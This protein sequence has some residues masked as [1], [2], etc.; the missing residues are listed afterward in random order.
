MDSIVQNLKHGASEAVKHFW[1]LRERQAMCQGASRGADQG[2]R[3][4]VTGGAQMDGFIRLLAD[5]VSLAGAQDH[6]VH[7]KKQVELPGYFRP[8]KEW[9]LVVV[10]DGALIAAI[11]T[12]SQ[13]GPSFG[14]NFNNRTEEA[15]GSA[16]DIWT[17]FREGAF[18]MRVRPWVGYLFLLESCARSLAPVAVK[19]PHFPVFSE[20]RQA[21]YTKRYVLFCTRLVREKHYDSAALL[22]SE[23]SQGTEGHYEEPAADLTLEAFVRSLFAHVYAHCRG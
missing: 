10:Q 12:K 13:V 3:R 14:N 6:C 1:K 4:A 11:E 15:M 22:T 21:S 5:V 2:E 20:F 7:M 8:T 16:L 9:D 18:S 23:R 19:E 17:A